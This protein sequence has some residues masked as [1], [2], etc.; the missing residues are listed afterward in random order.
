M[1][2]HGS[3][4][5]IWPYVVGAAGLVAIAVATAGAALS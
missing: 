1:N 4:R 2:S 3:H 5:E